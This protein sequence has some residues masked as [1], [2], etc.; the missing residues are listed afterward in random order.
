MSPRARQRPPRSL[1]VASY[2]LRRFPGNWPPAKAA[3]NRRLPRLHRRTAV[4]HRQRHFHLQAPFY[5]KAKIFMLIATSKNPGKQPTHEHVQ[6]TP[7]TLLFTQ[8]PFFDSAHPLV[9][10]TLSIGLV[11]LE[12]SLEQPTRKHVQ[13]PSTLLLTQQPFFDSAHPLIKF[14]LSRELYNRSRARDEATPLIIITCCCLEKADDQ[15]CDTRPLQ[16]APRA[17]HGGPEPVSTV[18]PDAPM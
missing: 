10:F 16:G 7:S 8:Q 18:T 12:K 15:R 11:D 13:R 2:W 1:A 4:L 6:R 5:F 14:N 9:K 3:V 17:P